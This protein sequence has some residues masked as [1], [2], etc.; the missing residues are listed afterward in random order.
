VFGHSK[1]MPA[2][3]GTLTDPHAPMPQGESGLSTGS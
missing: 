1:S 3:T 2:S